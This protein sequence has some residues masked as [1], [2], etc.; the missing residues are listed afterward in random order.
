MKMKLEKTP[1]FWM[2]IVGGLI[3]IAVGILLLPAWAGMDLF[4]SSWS[5]YSVNIMISGLLLAYILLYL[6]KRI[7]RYHNTPAQ[8]V[9]VVELVLMAVLA[10]VCAISEFVEYG[11]NFGGPCQIFG[12]ALW[13]RGAS[14]VYTGYYCD[15]DLVKEVEQEKKA[16]KKNAPSEETEKE[17]EK[18]NKK[19]K[20]NGGKTEKPKAIESKDA[21]KGRVDDFTVWRLTVAILLITAGAYLFVKP[22]FEK[23]HLQ[24]VFSCAII[25]IACFIVVLGFILKPKRIKVENESPVKKSAEGKEAAAAAQSDTEMEAE[26]A[27]YL[28]SGKVKINLDN[29][30]NAMTQTAAYDAVKDDAETT[31]NSQQESTKAEKKAKKEA[32][33]EA[34]K[35]TAKE[36]AKTRSAEEEKKTKAKKEN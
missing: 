33:N 17:T 31:E 22:A 8:T 32:E 4:F 5:A 35:K 36:A 13:V 24:W 3:S 15:S 7:R 12:I 20:G 34:P 2:Y 23:I 9:A 10:V 27:G 11:I 26:A 1:S 14:G 16:K 30:A 28:E 19:A 18:S 25:A 6:V 21:P 29:S